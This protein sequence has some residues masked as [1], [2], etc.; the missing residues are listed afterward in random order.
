M[1]QIEKTPDGVVA[2]HR[3]KTA[4]RLNHWVVAISFVLLVLSGLAIYHPAFF[5]LGGLFG[6]GQNVRAIHPWFG[7]VLCV[8]FLGMFFRFWKANLINRNDIVW[9]SSPA[10]VLSDHEET[11]P[12]IGKYNGGQKGIFWSMT[13]L[14]LLLLGT[15]LIIWDQ[16]FAASTTIDTKRIAVLGHSFAG[17]AIICVWIIHVYAAIW[18]RGTMQA[19]TKGTVTGGWAWKHHRRWLRDLAGGKPSA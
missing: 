7:V 2:V 18:V 8:S 14:L 16:Y 9:M 19:M 5:F 6:G 12:E 4:E 1:S 10:A 13:I 3:Y 11:L 17:I 15:G